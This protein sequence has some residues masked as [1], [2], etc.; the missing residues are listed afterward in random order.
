MQAIGVLEL[1][2]T[3]KQSL[4]EL[5]PDGVWIMAEIIS[6]QVHAASGHAYF[7]LGEKDPISGKDARIKANCWRTNYARIHKIFEKQSGTP[8]QKGLKILV[9]C[10]ISYHEHYGLSLQIEEIDA[11]YTL[12]EISKRK[13]EALNKLD[14][15]GLLYKNKQ[16]ELPPVLQRIAVI[17]SAS[18][19]GME[20]FMRQLEQNPY[21]YAFDVTLFAATMQGADTEKTVVNALQAIAKRAR[22]FDIAVMVR[23]GGADSDLFWFDSFAIGKAI[24]ELGIPLITGIG[25][26]KNETVADILAH[27][28]LKTPTAVAQYCIQS[29]QD[30][31][32]TML[33]FYDRLLKAAYSRVIEEQI[34]LN[35]LYYRLQIATKY[36]LAS[37]QHALQ[38]IEQRMKIISKVKLDKYATILNVME[39][40]VAL[41]HPEHILARGY[42]IT[43]LNGKVI[44]SVKE[45]SKGGV[46]ETQLKDGKV[47]SVVQ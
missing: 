24:A 26:E 30:F 46:L 32:Q 19:A 17:S 4:E 9:Y 21:G 41:L 2:R 39:Q 10:Y 31:E 42:S 47:Q 7:E 18:S 3:I 20:D 45:I 5:F 23:G 12:G 16:L 33:S 6:L 29:L 44:T 27:T 43:R 36:A 22:K 28:K 14:A 11:T 38:G 35:A 1:S 8:L 34:E 40:K 15:E 37:G 13:A 25:H